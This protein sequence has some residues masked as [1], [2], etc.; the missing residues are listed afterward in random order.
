MSGETKAETGPGSVELNVLNP[1]APAENKTGK[2]VDKKGSVE[3]KTVLIPAQVENKTDKKDGDGDEHAHVAFPADA[4]VG[5][6]SHKHTPVKRVVLW[7]HLR[8]RTLA[9]LV[10]G[11]FFGTYT[12]GYLLTYYATEQDD[13][14]DK[15]IIF[16]NEFNPCVFFDH[17]PA[18]I[19]TCIGISVMMIWKSCMSFFW[20][21]HILT[22]RQGFLKVMF[23]GLLMGPLV[24][25]QFCFVNVFTANLYEDGYP[26]IPNPNLFNA[27]VRASMTRD[28]LD[29][30]T[31][32]MFNEIIWH[33]IWFLSY[34]IGDLV[35]GVV[36]WTQVYKLGHPWVPAKKGFRKYRAFTIFKWAV[37]FI[38]FAS[39]SLFVLSVSFR[40]FAYNS[41][42]GDRFYVITD[43]NIY[44]QKVVFWLTTTFNPEAWFFIPG[45]LQ[46]YALPDSVGLL[47]AVRMQTN[48]E[49]VHKYHSEYVY[50]GDENNETSD[51]QQQQDQ[52]QQ[53]QQHVR[54]HSRNHVDFGKFWT[55]HNL[56]PGRLISFGYMLF[57]PVLVISFGF[58]NVQEGDAWAIASGFRLKPYAFV[59]VPCILFMFMLTAFG[60]ILT[61]ARYELKIF[62]AP[63]EPTQWQIWRGRIMGIL[64]VLCM[65]GV[66]SSILLV[67]PQIKGV[68]GILLLL[69][70]PIFFWVVVA[71]AENDFSPRDKARVVV[72]L[73]V[74]AI[75]VGC[76][77]NSVASVLALCVLAL[78]G[79]ALPEEQ[80]DRIQL[81]VAALRPGDK[82]D[83]HKHHRTLCWSVAT[84]ESKHVEHH[85]TFASIRRRLS[86][87]SHRRPS[88]THVD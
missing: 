62:A 3:L 56:L 75:L 68:V 37:C 72:Y 38:F 14:T 8:Y 7:F 67:L 69:V 84:V 11:F 43:S 2:T 20:M 70:V 76:S 29:G 24:V 54:D 35:L 81:T 10:V 44:F 41:A 86:R 61:W 65:M 60:M 28:E 52:E 4:L 51:Q 78:Y 73:V 48:K 82:S 45:S 66:V 19:I 31:P 59:F 23:Y 49:N 15:I 80:M 74:L 26:D 33:S 1:A 22:T 83:D 50:Y 16:Y 47:F 6:D 79:F 21:I 9:H 13:A 71:F 63:G 18:N 17:Y 34:M 39:Y 5:H 46:H 36:H 12:I 88:R 32:E 77:F 85:P 57:V 53:Q 27:T 40:L 30:V 55:A 64:V 58:D 87:L 25:S 42:V